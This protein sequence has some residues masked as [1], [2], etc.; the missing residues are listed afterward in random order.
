MSQKS[1]CLLAVGLGGETKWWKYPLP[2]DM[3]HI[4]T[5]I[6]QNLKYTLGIRSLDCV[7]T[8]SQKVK[9]NIEL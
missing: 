2:W 6:C 8:V 5:C 3:C 4:D 9:T 1:C 7:Y